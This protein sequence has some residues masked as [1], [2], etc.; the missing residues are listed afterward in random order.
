[1]F[2]YQS[3]VE[4]VRN[5]TAQHKKGFHV[6]CVETLY[7]VLSFMSPAYDRRMI[8]GPQLLNMEERYKKPTRKSC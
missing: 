4:G 8:L 2:S 1:M 6:N 3:S 7:V 5:K